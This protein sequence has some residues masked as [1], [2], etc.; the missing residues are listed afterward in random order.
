MFYLSLDFNNIPSTSKLNEH[1][2][3]PLSFLALIEY[4]PTF[5]G[6]TDLTKSVFMPF[7]LDSITMLSDFSSNI[8]SLYLHITFS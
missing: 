7:P 2:A 5:N 8:P 1:S 4:F 6:V 3:S